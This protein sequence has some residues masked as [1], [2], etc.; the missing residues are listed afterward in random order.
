MSAMTS[1]FFFDGDCGFCQW[2]AEKLQQLTGGAVGSGE[3]AIRP[4]WTGGHPGTP[5]RVAAHIATHAVY[6]RCHG[7]ASS[8]EGTKNYAVQILL[9]HK[10]IG[11]CLRD[12]GAN[13]AVR[14]AGRVL[15]FPLLF[16]L[17]AGIYRLVALN[18]HK[19]GP[20]VGVQACRI[21]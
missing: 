19:L 17:F 11:Q 15:T 16:P 5:A 3:L 20:L 6:A 7:E 10:G 12:H 2:S 21:N 4:A 18:R 13:K 1:T 14:G 8:G 9:G